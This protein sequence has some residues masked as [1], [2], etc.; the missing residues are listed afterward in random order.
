[1]HI[2][3]QQLRYFVEVVSRRS[4]NAAARN[5]H[6][7]QS[8]L[9][10]RMAQLEHQMRSP[11]FVRS[12]RGIELTEQGSLLLDRALLLGRELEGIHAAGTPV[13]P[14][15]RRGLRV[16]I[17]SGIRETLLPGL[18]AD[19]GGGPPESTLF[20][21]SMPVLR[22]QVRSGQLHVVL[23][24]KPAADPLLT[25]EPL[26]R[27]RLMLVLPAGV[28]PDTLDAL[29]FLLTTEDE[30]MG[31]LIRAAVESAGLAPRQTLRVT[32]SEVARRAI[33]ARQGYSVLHYSL[34]A[35]A[36]GCCAIEVRPL[37]ATDLQFGL[38]YRR[39]RE[40]R[41]DMEAFVARLRSALTD[42]I[43]HL[44]RQ[45]IAPWPDTLA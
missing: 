16:G 43:R 3:H 8:A 30:Q 20:E 19:I 31:K 44:P 26:W 10:R 25:F 36:A 5:L 37:D 18:L 45:G 22:E 23:V 9:S 21:S 14:A 42:R 11:L 4:I 29:P 15:S 1:M 39:D 34:I 12:S 17:L 27:E 40:P 38:L 41:G 32:P 7:S 6:I 24:G 13:L 2:D 28:V 33:A 35:D